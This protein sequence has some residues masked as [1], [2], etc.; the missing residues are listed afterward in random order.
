MINRYLFRAMQLRDAVGE[1]GM[2]L[3]FMCINGH[4]RQL[5]SV[6]RRRLLPYI[7]CTLLGVAFK[8]STRWLC[9]PLFSP[10]F[11]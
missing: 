2:L 9:H 3:L 6:I 1:K 5:G 7:K 11:S 4:V 10:P 8:G